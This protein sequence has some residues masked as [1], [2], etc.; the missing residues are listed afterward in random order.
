VLVGVR[1]ARGS[2]SSGLVPTSC[3][4]PAIGLA[5]GTVPAGGVVRLEITGPA[6]ASYAV[7]IDASAASGSG[8]QATATPGTPGTAT[9]LLVPTVP[10]PGCKLTTS[11]VLDPDIKPGNHVV[12]LFRASADGTSYTPVTEV[13]LTVK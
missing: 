11:S 10:L 12:V 7:W 6:T 9:D 13:P 4:T 3:V 1:L 2:E 5:A 8:R